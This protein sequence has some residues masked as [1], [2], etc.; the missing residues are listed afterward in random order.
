[1]SKRYTYTRTIETEAGK[2]NFAAVEFDSFDEAINAVDK[3]IR[4]RLL[5]F[6]TPDLPPPGAIGKAP[7]AVPEEEIIEEKVE[8]KTSKPIVTKK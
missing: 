3:G 4:D 2:E 6:R 8:S 5:S 7:I 1:M